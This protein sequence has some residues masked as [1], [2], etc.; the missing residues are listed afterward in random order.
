MYKKLMLS[1]L[2]GLYLISSCYALKVTLQWDTGTQSEITQYN[3][4]YGYLPGVHIGVGAIEGNSPVRITLG[5]DENPDPLLV[6]FSLNLPECI[7]FYYTV[8]ALDSMDRESNKS[9]EVSTKSG[10]A[11]YFSFSQEH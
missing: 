3:V 4:Y 5:Q 9:N 10:A 8:S 1:L 7:A 11:D 2:M 6:E